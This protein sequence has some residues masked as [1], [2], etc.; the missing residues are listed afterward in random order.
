MPFAAA[1]IL[2]VLSQEGSV[3]TWFGDCEFQPL[4]QP[5]CNPH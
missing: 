1:A 2:I 4:P 5:A 3:T